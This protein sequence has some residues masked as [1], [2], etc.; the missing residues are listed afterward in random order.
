[1]YTEVVDRTQHTVVHRPTYPPLDGNVSTTFTTSVTRPSQIYV[2]KELL[3]WE[4]VLSFPK[5]LQV[6]PRPAEDHVLAVPNISSQG[7]TRD[8]FHRNKDRMNA[9]A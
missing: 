1:M 8:S 9:S 5:P 6:S 4:T 2:K 3:Y 7:I